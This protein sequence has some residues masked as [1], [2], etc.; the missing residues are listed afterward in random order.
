[1]NEG[2]AEFAKILDGSKV[3]ASAAPAVMRNISRRLVLP[4]VIFWFNVSDRR[5]G[6]VLMA[7]SR[8]SR[9]SIFNKMTFWAKISQYFDRNISL[10]SLVYVNEVSVSATLVL[11]IQYSDLVSMEH[12]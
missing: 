10:F 6:Y 9:Q 12:Q 1:V 8:V 7:G 4:F 11:E 5:L 2:G 3:A